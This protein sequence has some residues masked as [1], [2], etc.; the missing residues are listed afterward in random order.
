MRGSDA[1]RYEILF[2]LKAGEY[3]AAEVGGIRTRTI[4]AGD[5]L[6]V[7]C[8]PITKVGEAA[9]SEWRRRRTGPAQEKVN[10]EQAE[11]RIRRLIDA[12][13]TG[14]DYVVTL[15]WDY[16]AIDRFHMS[17]EAALKK[18]D[19]LGLPVDEDEARWEFVKFV[20]R[21]KYHMGRRGNDPRELK[22]IYVL[23]VTHERK[24]FDPAP[25]YAHHHFHT[26]I[27][28]PGLAVDDIKA[29]WPHGDAHTDRL[30]FRADGPARIAHYITKQRG[31]ERV[32]GDG[33]RIRRWACS[34]NL[35]EPEVTVS[36]RKVSRRRAM[37]IAQDVQQYG[38][39][40]FERLYPGYQCVSDPTVRYSDF[41]AGAYIFARLR[42]VDA[43]APWERARGKKAGDLIRH[44][45]A[46]PPSP[47]GEGM[48][49]R[50]NR[51]RN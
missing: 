34:K 9:R 36:N 13:F 39:E 45:C 5:A 16:S 10:R 43:R 4:R 23:E 48:G 20:K 44:G 51:R 18:W 32:D 24:P 27:H 21:L 35:T 3:D 50:A 37:M 28:A 11:K 47:S 2:D 25:L 29:L 7:E 40:I 41:V 8:F 19:A 12:N 33:R 15:T 31:L 46:V 26:V 49:K 1:T 6:E 30:S 17:H 42:R 38:R 22:Y 14:E